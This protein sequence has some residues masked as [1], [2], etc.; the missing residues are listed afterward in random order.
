MD[1]AKSNSG[2]P[3]EKSAWPR[4]LARS[5]WRNG[6]WPWTGGR[7]IHPTTASGQVEGGRVQALGYAVSEA[8]IHEGLGNL[9]TKK[10]GEYR[11]FAADEVPALAVILVQT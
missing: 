4:S 11:I 7:V 2:I 3:H 1:F 10:F 6:V 5:P 9:A 8:M